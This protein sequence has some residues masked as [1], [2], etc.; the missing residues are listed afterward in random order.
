M[1]Y[2]RSST[3]VLISDTGDPKIAEATLAGAKAAAVATVASAVPTVSHHPHHIIFAA[4]ISLLQADTKLINRL[5][6]MTCR[7]IH[8]LRSSAG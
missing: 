2:A 6:M 1:G 4:V 7:S 5:N 8:N 3:S